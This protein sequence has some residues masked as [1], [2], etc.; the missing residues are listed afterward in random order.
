MTTKPI[1]I[2]MGDAAGIGP[3]I[4]AKA[5]RDHAA[6]TRGCF[7]AGDVAAI[8]RGAGAPAPFSCCRS[9]TPI[10]EATSGCA[11]S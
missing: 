10:A 2:T 1:A 8:R 4:I 9:G 3:E 11:V 5:F 7:V 6:R